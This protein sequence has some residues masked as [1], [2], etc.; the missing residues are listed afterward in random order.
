MEKNELGSI[1]FKTLQNFY[2]NKQL[3]ISS[4]E[5]QNILD[6]AKINKKNSN[7]DEILKIIKI[8]KNHIELSNQKITKKVE[9]QEYKP[10]FNNLDNQHD[11]LDKMKDDLQNNLLKLE[12]NKEYIIEPKIDKSLLVQNFMDTEKKEFEHLIIIDSTDKLDIDKPNNFKISLGSNNKKGS[13]DINFQE[14]ISIELI[15]FLIK[16]TEGTSDIIPPYLLLEI[17]ELG[18]NYKGT[19]SILNKVF[20]RLYNFELLNLGTNTNYREYTCE[21][22]I[23]KF[24]PCKNLTKLSIKI[25]NPDGTLY[26]FNEEDKDTNTKFP[27]VSMTFKITVLQKNLISNFINQS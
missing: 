5:I 12:E 18:S 10:I 27:Y 24:N 6:K 13:I 7:K 21:N 2:P 26:S 9:K 14:V 4:L 25:L 16:N 19:K 23:K 8:L 17:E 15:D 3:P 11:Y 22:L 20:A 1:I